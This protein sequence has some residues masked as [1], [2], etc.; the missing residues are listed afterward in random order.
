MVNRAFRTSM[1]VGVRVEAESLHTGDRCY[2]CSAYL[3]FV[4][5]GPDGRPRA[6][7]QVYPET[8]DEER[9]YES[10]MKRREGRLA[11]RDD[12][13]RP[14]VAAHEQL[15]LDVNQG[16]YVAKEGKI[17]GRRVNGC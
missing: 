3:T 7:P 1:E 11:G 16:R 14:L 9:R 12:A 8:A 15:S 17:G 10:A 5:L 2:C 6:V 4:A 13:T